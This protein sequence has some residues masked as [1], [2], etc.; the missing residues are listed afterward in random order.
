MLD[1]RHVDTAAGK[2]LLQHLH[3]HAAARHLG[4]LDDL[5]GQPPGRELVV[6]PGQPPGGEVEVTVEHDGRADLRCAARP[7]R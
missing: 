7:A 2:L 4:G 5:V 3:E 6:G 1:E